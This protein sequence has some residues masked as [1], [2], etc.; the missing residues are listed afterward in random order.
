MGR[1]RGKEGGT[2]VRVGRWVPW[3]WLYRGK[4]K[5]E[6]GEKRPVA[7]TAWRSDGA[8]DVARERCGGRRKR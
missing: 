1:R 7:E 6:A 5:V 2:R 4:G 3:W 8:G